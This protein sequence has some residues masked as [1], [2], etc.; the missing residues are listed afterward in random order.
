MKTIVVWTKCGHYRMRAITDVRI[1]KH[2]GCP[3]CGNWDMQKRYKVSDGF[4]IKSR[5]TKSTT[6]HNYKL[7]PRK[8][9]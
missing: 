4:K 2:A 9:V 8:Y 7:I 5:L 1:S 3:T 6:Y